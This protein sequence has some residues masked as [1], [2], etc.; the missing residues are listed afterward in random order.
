MAS[1][2]LREFELLAQER[3]GGLMVLG[4]ELLRGGLGDHRLG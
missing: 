1:N 4:V 2:S 3:R